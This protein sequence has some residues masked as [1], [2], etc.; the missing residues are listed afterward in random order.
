MT[1]T[2]N[3][4]WQSPFPETDKTIIEVDRF[5]VEEDGEHIISTLVHTNSPSV[6][7]FSFYINADGDTLTDLPATTYPA[8]DNAFPLSHT[9]SLVKGQVITFEWLGAVFPSGSS[10]EVTW[11]IT[12]PSPLDPLPANAFEA[13]DIDMIYFGQEAEALYKGTTLVWQSLSSPVITE[14]VAINHSGLIGIA[15]YEG[16]PIDIIGQDFTPDSYVMI[17]NTRVRPSFTPTPYHISISIPSM[18]MGVY[19]LR[20]VNEGGESNSAQ[21]INRGHQLLFSNRTNSYQ[22]SNTESYSYPLTSGSVWGCPVRGAAMRVR[23]RASWPNDALQWL[24]YDRTTGYQHFRADGTQL[25]WRIWN[26]SSSS[27][28]NLNGISTLN[29]PVHNGDYFR[30]TTRAWGTGRSVALRLDDISIATEYI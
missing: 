24:T 6:C 19:D 25:D 15:C 23:V 21:F 26:N 12:A 30:L 7:I 9:V 5:V 4:S 29:N 11:S 10:V 18:S 16:H 22:H 2:H 3:G 17:G 14:V 8:G 20:V 28:W 27:A 13:E 1:V